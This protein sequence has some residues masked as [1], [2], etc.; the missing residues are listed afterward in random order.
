V[1]SDPHAAALALAT[2]GWRQ[3]VL[4]V[5]VRLDLGA[6]LGARAAD[7]EEVC[8]SL[9]TPRQATQLFLAACE[10]LGL[11]AEREGE[12]RLGALGD[13]LR[14]AAADPLLTEWA[15]AGADPRVSGALWDLLRGPGRSAPGATAGA[16]PGP[17]G[18]AALGLPYG[19]ALPPDAARARAVLHALH[20]AGAQA[21]AAALPPPAGVVIERGGQGIYARALLERHGPLQI[22]LVEAAPW[23]LDAWDQD[24]VGAPARPR[25]VERYG[26]EPAALA[27]VAQTTQTVSPGTLGARLRELASSLADR[28]HLAVV[29]R[30]RGGVGRPLAP[31]LALLELAAGGPGWCP[32]M[33]QVAD[34]VQA[35]GF[36]GAQTLLLPEPDAAILARRA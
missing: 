31:L 30:F 12:Y 11:V 13:M 1:S 34:A 29:G 26:G 18:V 16:A 3:A 35:A 7:L 22:A 5:A 4:A 24:R 32:T 21:L 19:E 8:Y 23:A 10:S 36:E 17:A 25:S 9:G 15:A 14:A 20:G 28:A 27:I 33:E 6:M 2:G